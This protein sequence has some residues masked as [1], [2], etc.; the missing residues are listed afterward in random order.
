VIE[1]HE[2]TLIAFLDGVLN[3]FTFLE[4][5]FF[6]SIKLLITKPGQ[7]S[8]NIADGNQVP[9]MRLLNLFFVA[10]FFYF[11]LFVFDSFNSSLYTQMN[12][13]GGHSEQ[14]RAL[15]KAKIEAEHLD[16]REFQKNYE[17]ST[18]NLSKLLLITLTLLLTGIFWIFNF[19]KKRHFVDYMLV[20]LEYYTFELLLV[21]IVLANAIKHLIRW[22]QPYGYDW[23]V[24]LTDAV[25]STIG[26][27][28]AV[29]FLFN[30][31]RNFFGNK[32]YWALPKAVA[33]YWLIGQT[34]HFYRMSLFY[35]TFYTL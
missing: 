17:A 10:N 2:R 7:L 15:V 32:W 1:P 29:W 24:L 34:I 28:L 14:V 35:L 21:L 25:F 26:M 31:E 5:K 19:S 8:R 3:A 23:S 4:G 13:L 22:V 9:Y 12:S 27:V 33:I 6:R 11:F 20:S 18:V 16:I 30:I